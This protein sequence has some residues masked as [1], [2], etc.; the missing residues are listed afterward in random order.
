MSLKLIFCTAVLASVWA[1]AISLS[2]YEENK[3]KSVVLSESTDINSFDAIESKNSNRFS[4]GYLHHG[5]L[6]AQS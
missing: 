5:S 3:V 1:A 4:I 2:D 6:V